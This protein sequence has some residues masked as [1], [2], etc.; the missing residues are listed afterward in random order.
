MCI[1]DRVRTLLYTLNLVRPFIIYDS[2]KPKDLEAA[3][4]YINFVLTQ[5]FIPP[6][7]LDETDPN[8]KNSF[9]L[10]K[11]SDYDFMSPPKGLSCMQKHLRLERE[12]RKNGRMAVSYTHL[13]LPTI[14]SV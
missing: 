13:T 11:R 5:R 10:P 14:C 2:Y 9:Q 1:R 6:N 3:K 8:E 12:K 7:L 4:E